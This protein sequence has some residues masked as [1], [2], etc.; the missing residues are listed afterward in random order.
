MQRPAGVTILAVLGFVGAACLAMFGLIALL[1]GAM[2][3]RMANRPFGVMAGIGGAMI[4]AVILFFAA[5]Y[6]ITSIGLLSLQNWARILLVILVGLSLVSSAFGLLGALAHFRI[7]L[8]FWRAIFAA[9]E[10]WILMYLFQP[11]VKQAFGATS[12]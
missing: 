10:V 3:S 7:F 5:L 6:L 2:F 12:F 1:G 11:N 9:I 8:F 4:G